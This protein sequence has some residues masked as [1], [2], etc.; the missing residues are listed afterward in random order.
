MKFRRIKTD[1]PLRIDL[2]KLCRN[3]S[4]IGPNLKSNSE[5]FSFGNVLQYDNPELFIDGSNK[6][7]KQKQKPS[8]N[9]TRRHK[10][11]RAF[12]LLCFLFHCSLHMTEI[13]LNLS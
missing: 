8:S 2:I 9:V 5:A 7:K 12:I 11:T 3:T 4:Q 6:I 13:N 10:I 1:K